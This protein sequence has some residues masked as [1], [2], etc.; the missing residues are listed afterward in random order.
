MDP[1][2]LFQGDGPQTMVAAMTTNVTQPICVTLQPVFCNRNLL[3]IKVLTAKV[4]LQSHGI[5]VAIR[6]GTAFK[7]FC[8]RRLQ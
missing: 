1:V 6:E 4:G 5:S 2:F 7:N 3:K 8:L